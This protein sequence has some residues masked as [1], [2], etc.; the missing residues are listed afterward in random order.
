MVGGWV[1]KPK[2]AKS[3]HGLRPKALLVFVAQELAQA[4]NLRAIRAVS[5][6]LH[7]S[8]HRDYRLNRSRPFRTNSE[9]H[10]SYHICA[11]KFLPD[12]CQNVCPFMPFRAYLC[13]MMKC[14]IFAL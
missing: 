9:Y 4:W 7:M 10:K 12:S 11:A 6:A 14:A 13:N 2:V 3:L 8:Q 5:N 1:T